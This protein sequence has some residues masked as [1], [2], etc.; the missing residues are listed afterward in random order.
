LKKIL[1]SVLLLT[2]SACSGQYYKL[3]QPEFN[4]SQYQD[5]G[6][7]SQTTT[8]IHLFGFIPIQLNDKLERA[9]NS[10]ISSKGGDSMTNVE[11][12][13]RWYWAYVLNIYKMDVTGTVLKKK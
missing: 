2:L 12:R 11:V 7:A 3:K 8:G 10:A 4:K 9:M 1:A 5:L 13:E 6:V